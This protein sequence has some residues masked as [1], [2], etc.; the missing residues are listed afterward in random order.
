[1]LLYISNSSI[2]KSLIMLQTSIPPTV[3]Y[4]KSCKICG[5]FAHASRA[6]YVENDVHLEMEYT[7]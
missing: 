1:M 5:L 7:T 2:T 3:H 6:S 4:I